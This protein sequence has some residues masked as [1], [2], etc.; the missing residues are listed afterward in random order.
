MRSKAAN[1]FHHENT[2]DREQSG[3]F[4][5]GIHPTRKSNYATLIAA[6]I[7][8]SSLCSPCLRGETYCIT[9]PRS[10][11][12]SH[13]RGTSLRSVRRRHASGCVES[14]R[15]SLCDGEQQCLSRAPARTPPRAGSLL[16]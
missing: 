13:H 4:E 2:K 10:P 15:L 11:P 9:A 7:L 8:N 14:L 5:I 12:Q 1:R 6:K 3:N 16:P